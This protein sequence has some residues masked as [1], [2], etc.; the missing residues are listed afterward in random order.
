M[1]LQFFA[2]S[3]NLPEGLSAEDFRWWAEQELR[4]AVGGTDPD[5]EFRKLARHQI[6]VHKIPSDR[7]PVVTRPQ[8]YV[9]IEKPDVRLHDGS[10]LPPRGLRKGT[11]VVVWYRPGTD[12]WRVQGSAGCAR[13]VGN[14]FERWEDVERYQVIP[15]PQVHETEEEL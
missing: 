8:S 4:A 9:K 15:P 1:A 3:V 2:I 5:S 14:G 12:C 6:S 13:I 7:R 11:A 10:F